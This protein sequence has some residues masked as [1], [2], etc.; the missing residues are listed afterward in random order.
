MGL[1][2][3]VYY[4]SRS[5]ANYRNELSTVEFELPANAQLQR[6]VIWRIAYA[7]LAYEAGVLPNV[8]MHMKDA[9]DCGYCPF[10]S[11]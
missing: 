1:P 3:I 5:V 2:A 7:H 6:D 9:D 4:Q 8:P 11:G 10:V